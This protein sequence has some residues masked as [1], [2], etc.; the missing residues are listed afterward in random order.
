[1]CTSVLRCPCH[2]PGPLHR[3]DVSA[4]P[5]YGDSGIWSGSAGRGK[6]RK[7]EEETKGLCSFIFFLIFFFFQ[8]RLRPFGYLAG[9][10]RGPCTA[11]TPECHLGRDREGGYELSE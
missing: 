3:T 6:G 1:M 10:Y 7:G 8:M 4:T 11:P 9:G 2:L 5:D